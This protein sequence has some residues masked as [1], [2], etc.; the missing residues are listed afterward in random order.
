MLPVEKLLE[1]PTENA[2]QLPAISR[3]EVEQIRQSHADQW[4]EDRLMGAPFA[5]QGDPD[6][7]PAKMNFAP[8]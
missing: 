8:E 5:A 4:G 7:V 3:F 2:L 6:G 1:A